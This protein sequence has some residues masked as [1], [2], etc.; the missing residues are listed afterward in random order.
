MDWGHRAPDHL[1]D[2]IQ[3][4]LANPWITD[5]KVEIRA[6]KRAS[7]GMRIM[8]SEVAVREL[9]VDLADVINNAAVRGK[10]TYIT[11]R[12]RRIAAVVPVQIAEDAAAA[13]Q[14]KV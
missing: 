14:E 8:D 12:G 4:Y 5:V 3:D 13:Q 11:S 2:Q 6:T 7:N 1:A 10:I 9:R